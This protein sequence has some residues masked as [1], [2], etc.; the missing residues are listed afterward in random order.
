MLILNMV[1]S[2]TYKSDSL[3]LLFLMKSYREVVSLARE[4]KW[5]YWR[6]CSPCQ[7]L[8]KWQQASSGL[9]AGAGAGASC[10]VTLTTS[11]VRSLPVY[12]IIRQQL[13]E[14]VKQH[15]QAWKTHNMGLSSQSLSGSS[16]WAQHT[17]MKHREPHLHGYNLQLCQMIQNL[18]WI[19][20][21]E[22]KF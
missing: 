9:R 4:S 10:G 14:C 18:N 8:M 3:L 22:N 20:I 6:N 16:L 13:Q 12:D 1:F 5:F 7:E 15:L 21:L 17:L 2:N 11:R 19:K